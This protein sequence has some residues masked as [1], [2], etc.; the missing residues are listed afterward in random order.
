MSTEFYLHQIPE[1]AI[2]PHSLAVRT[3]PTLITSTPKFQEA[4]KGRQND[5][6]SCDATPW[7]TS[8][9]KRAFDVACVAPALLLISPILGIV[10]IA[11]RLTSPGPVIFRQGRAGQN[12]KIF[13]IYKFRTMVQNSEAI[14]PGHTAKGDPRITPMGNLLRRF[15][16]DELPQLYNVLRGD[17]SLVGPR[18]KLPDHEQ[19]PMTCRPGVT[20][21]ATLA[22]RDEQHILCEV[23]CERIEAFYQEYV[24]PLKIKLDAEYMRNATL[25]TDVRVL[26]ATV[27]RSG[28]HLTHQDLLQSSRRSVQSLQSRG[29]LAT[30]IAGD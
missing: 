21:A 18:P 7:C 15:K 28:K 14:G 2:A 8:V 24:I 1:S 27:L 9:W 19:T 30:E 16:L 26:F 20:G 4:T 3:S 12:R 29:H 10:A 17:M 5:G 22:F 6:L 13:T 25:A 11:V 23:P